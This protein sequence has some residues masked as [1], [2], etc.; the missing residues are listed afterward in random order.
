MDV[1]EIYGG[2]PAVDLRIWKLIQFS[3]EDHLDI[4]QSRLTFFGIP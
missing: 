3:V 4:I 1:V 2:L